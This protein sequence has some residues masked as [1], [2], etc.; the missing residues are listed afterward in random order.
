[1]HT[2]ELHP[3]KIYDVKGAHNLLQIAQIDDGRYVLYKMYAP[4]YGFINVLPF[5]SIKRRGQM[6]DEDTANKNMYVKSKEDYQKGSGTRIGLASIAGVFISKNANLDV[7]QSP[8]LLTSLIVVP[9]VLS[10][11]YIMCLH[12]VLRNKNQLLRDFKPNIILNL[13]SN[14]WPGRLMLVLMICFCLFSSGSLQAFFVPAVAFV[15]PFY[16]YNFL[17]DIKPIQETK[18]RIR[19]VELEDK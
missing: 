12:K 10:F 7:T 3:V 19:I 15:F 2:N 5:V 11:L 14:Y 6:I 18:N 17:P 9:A 8:F 1:M 16:V 4:W 13:Y